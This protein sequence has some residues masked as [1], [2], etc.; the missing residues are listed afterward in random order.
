MANGESSKEAITEPVE[1]LDAN[2]ELSAVWGVAW[3]A[4]RLFSGLADGLRRH[5]DNQYDQALCRDFCQGDSAIL[6]HSVW[7]KCH[8]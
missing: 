4:G 5:S 2:P 8:S 3:C 7:I 1:A 6:V